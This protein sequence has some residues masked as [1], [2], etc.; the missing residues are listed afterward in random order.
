MTPRPLVI[1]GGGEHAR[2]VAEAAVSRPDAWT[3]VGFTDTS[4]GPT[5]STTGPGRDVL[6]G[7]PCLGD[8]DDYAAALSGHVPSS[9]AAL[10]LGFR[11]DSAGRRR[12]V[13][14]YGDATWATVVHDRAWIATSAA[15]APGVV[16]L[17][18]AIVNAG[19]EVGSHALIN[20]QAVVEH[21]VVV[22][23]GSHVAPGAIIGGGTRLGADVQ[24]G[25]GA[26]IRDHLTIGDG[27]VIGMG[28]VVLED[29]APHTTVVGNPARPLERQSG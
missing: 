10:V 3:I 29:V 16:V 18:G 27:A 12:A 2:V 7:I 21:D 19:A 28:A 9:R 24:V 20:S 23:P 6:G 1:V 17:A 11:G 26:A 13:A 5:A 14:A 4:D 25:L 8:D 15:L 22:G